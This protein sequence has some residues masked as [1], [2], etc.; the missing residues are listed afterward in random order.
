V[1]TI[2]S[3]SIDSWREINKEKIHWRMKRTKKSISTKENNSN[4]Q[5]EK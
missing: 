5:R 2:F 4:L 3:E 1:C